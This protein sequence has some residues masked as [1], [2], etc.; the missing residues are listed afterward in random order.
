MSSASNSRLQTFV[1][2]LLSLVIATGLWYLVVGRDHVETQVELRVEY[3]GIPS[4]FVIGDG[5]VNNLSVRLRGSAE[6]LRTLHSR[7][8]VYTVDLSSLQRGANAIPLRVAEMPDLKPFEILEVHPSRLVLEVDALIERVIPLEDRLLPLPKHSPYFVSNIIMEPSFVTVKGPETR[9]EPLDRLIV[10]YDPSKNAS[11][12]VHEANVAIVA[13]PQVEITPPVTMLRYSLDPKTVSVSLARLI[14]LEDENGEYSIEPRRAEITLEVPEALSADDSYLQAAR[15]VVRP[16]AGVA[17]GT[18]VEMT[19]TVIVPSGATL[20]GLTPPAVTLTR[21]AAVPSD[22]PWEPLV[23]LYGVPRDAFG[24]EL[25]EQ[26]VTRSFSL[27]DLDLPAA[28]VAQ[29]D[30]LKVQPAGAAESRPHIS[31]VPA[32]DLPV[33]PVLPDISELSTP[34]TNAADPASQPS[35]DDNSKKDQAPEKQGE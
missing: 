28:P 21:S 15:V 3:R 25:S 11:E 32:A 5:L 35:G 1:S 33:V 10:V 4:G 14:Q 2:A 9:V 31:A 34:S 29:P 18:S 13:P 8:L 6:L 30:D 24:M 19:P 17:P 27:D 12:G 16:P 22:V 26:K 20:G 7:D 23:P